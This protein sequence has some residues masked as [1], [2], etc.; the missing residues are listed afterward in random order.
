MELF[1]HKYLSCQL[2][3]RHLHIILPV[4]I[5]DIN[6]CQDMVKFQLAFKSVPNIYCGRFSV[7][8]RF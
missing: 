3:L 5:M 6:K 7:S 8:A 2:K 1:K 4:L